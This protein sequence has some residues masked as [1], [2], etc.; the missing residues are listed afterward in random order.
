M[1][2]E[3]MKRK[4]SLDPEM[5]ERM[6]QESIQRAWN[7]ASINRRVSYCREAGL[8]IFAARRANPP[9]AVAEALVE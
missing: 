7:Q 6:R 5:E 2:V 3:R 9:A 8:S 1:L 4:G